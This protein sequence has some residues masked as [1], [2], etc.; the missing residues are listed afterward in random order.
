MGIR[1]MEAK[2]EGVLA[3]IDFNITETMKSPVRLPSH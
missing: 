3:E 2:G 1:L